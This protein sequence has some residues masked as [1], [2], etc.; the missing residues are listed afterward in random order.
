VNA[1]CLFDGAVPAGINC[2]DVPT[3]NVDKSYFFWDVEH[4]TKAA[5]ADV[6]AFMYRTLRQFYDR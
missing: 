2:H 5:P 4:P 1:T 3:F 6:G